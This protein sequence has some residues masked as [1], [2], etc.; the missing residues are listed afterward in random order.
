[1]AAH[2]VVDVEDCRGRGSSR[3]ADLWTTQCHPALRSAESGSQ[4]RSGHIHQDIDV[5]LMLV[6]MRRAAH[7]RG[8]VGD[9][10]RELGC[11]RQAEVSTPR[12]GVVRLRVRGT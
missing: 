12:C 11:R 7:P 2:D 4:A 9:P 1:V 5:P 3:S 6:R 10:S 8:E